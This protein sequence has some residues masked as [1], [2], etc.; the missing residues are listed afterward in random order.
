LIQVLSYDSSGKLT[1]LVSN[2]LKQNIANLT[3]IYHT[4]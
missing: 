2:T 4:I 1:N 3:W